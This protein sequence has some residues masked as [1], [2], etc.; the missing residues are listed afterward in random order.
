MLFLFTP[1]E[2]YFI[3]QCELVST[4]ANTVTEFCYLWPPDLVIGGH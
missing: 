1:S 4:V 2:L 3:K